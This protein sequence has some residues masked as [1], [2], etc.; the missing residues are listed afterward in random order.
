MVKLDY[1]SFSVN[2][3]VE[4]VHGKLRVFHL[5]V[6][7]DEGKKKPSGILVL[8]L[9]MSF[10]SENEKHTILQL[11]LITREEFL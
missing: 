10:K 4:V 6:S 3:L 1:P 11:F 5:D 2:G 7:A 8:R 9:E